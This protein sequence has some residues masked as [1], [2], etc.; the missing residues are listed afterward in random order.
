V[1]LADG[2]VR[3]EVA[4]PSLHAVNGT[5]VVTTDRIQIETARGELG[6][7]PFVVTGEV[8]RRPG[9]A[10]QV[11]LS[12]HGENLLLFRNAGVKVRADSDVK[13]TGPLDRLEV[14]GDVAV[15]DGRLVKNI[16]FLAA[17]RPSGRP[18]QEGGM[19]LFSLPDPPFS[20]AR[21][22]VRITAKQPFQIRTN[23][24]RGTVRPEVLLTG[25]GELPVVAGEVYVDPTRIRLPAGVLRVDAGVVR[26]LEGDPERPRLDLVGG[27]KMLGYDISLHVD[28][29]YDEPTVT[30]SST[31]PLADEDLLLLLLTGLPPKTGTTQTSRRMAGMNVA[32]YV[33]RGLLERW[34]GNEEVESEESILDRFEIEVGRGVTRTGDETIDSQFRLAEHVLRDGDVLYLTAEKDTFDDVNAGVKI[35]F[36]FQ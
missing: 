28:G 34:F 32:V 20:D 26:F 9:A 4:V 8:E 17:L 13:V 7:A 5:A 3:P 23:V 11:A 21:L 35:V 33:G 19:R 2:E 36:R 16:D 10:P 6:G 15:T 24:A 30:L 25:T 14:T 29:P 18:N 27:A 31:P 12:L 22:R 1:S